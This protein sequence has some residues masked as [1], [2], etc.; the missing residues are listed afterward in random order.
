MGKYLID[1]HTLLWASENSERLS[2]L[3]KKIIDLKPNI[4]LV[5]IVSFWEIAIKTSLGKLETKIPFNSL[6]QYLIETNYTLLN[7]DFDALGYVKTLPFHHRDPFDRMLIAQAITENIPIISA[8][9]KFD[10]YSEI[11]RI[12]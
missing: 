2:S 8:D 3:A 1:T 6:K 12:W 7:I 9:T 5:S 10:L 11:Q 4:I